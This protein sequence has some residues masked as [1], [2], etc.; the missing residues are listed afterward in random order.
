MMLVLS[1]I[2]QGIVSGVIIAAV[3]AGMSLIYRVSHVT[4]F[5]HGSL[6][7]LA[8]YVT[9][10]LSRRF[11]IDPLYFSIPMVPI[12]GLVGLAL[13]WTL[14]RPVRRRHHL[15]LVQLL[16]GASFVIDSLLLMRYGADLQSISN[17]LSARFV[18]IL[19]TG[20]GL[21]ELFASSIS[22]LAL[23]TLATAVSLSDW[24]RKFRAVA[25]DELAS[26]L[27]GLSIEGVE[28]VSWMTGVA[29]L[30]LIAPA[31]GGVVTLTPD[32]GLHYTVLALVTMIVGGMG[33]LAGTILAGMLVGVAQSLG[34]LFL[35]G[36]YGALLPYALLVA[37]L[38]VRP[39]GV[40]SIMGRA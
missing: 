2:L 30:G 14:I 12:M 34:L 26:R 40:A 27:A 39:G 15:L 18:S 19:G 13:Y 35:S 17:S 11:A 37:V 22:A 9:L 1:G 5:L 23:C 7:A 25:S 32:M 24:G 21:N 33:S 38:I 20:F 16:L 3:A 10:D 6:L 8:L 36:S 29:M 31:M 28:A 4:N